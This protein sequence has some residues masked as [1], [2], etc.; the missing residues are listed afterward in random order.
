MVEFS[1]VGADLG[2]DAFEV[3]IVTLIALEAVS[4]LVELSTVAIDESLNSI[5]GLLVSRAEF[6]N[7]HM[8]GWDSNLGINWSFL[9]WL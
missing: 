9:D 2:A 4:I 1:A 5:I 6:G 7:R 3:E 8:L